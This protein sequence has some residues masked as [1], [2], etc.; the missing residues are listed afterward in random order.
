MPIT[1]KSFL[2]NAHSSLLIHH[3]C[4]LSSRASLACLAPSSNAHGEREGTESSLL[5]P[6]G[7]LESNCSG[8]KIIIALQFLLLHCT[9]S[10]AEFLRTS[11]H[12]KKISSLF[13]RSVISF[14]KEESRRRETTQTIWEI[15]SEWEH[16]EVEGVCSAVLNPPR[17]REPGQRWHACTH[18][19]L[20]TPWKIYTYMSRKKQQQYQCIGQSSLWIMGLFYSSHYTPVYFLQWMY[21]TQ[22][23][24]FRR[25]TLVPSTWY[26]Q[27]LKHE[28]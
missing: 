23:F 6:C 14:L 10:P 15:H 26:L 9:L 27:G 22:V 16:F 1:L 28:L 3:G 2:G 25:M 21:N 4:V 24:H 12:P 17:G 5:V 20:C 8:G 13:T 11:P 7:S 19:S 18:T